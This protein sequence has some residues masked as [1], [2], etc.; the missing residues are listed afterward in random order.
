MN[1]HHDNLAPEPLSEQSAWSP[2]RE[3]YIGMLAQFSLLEHRIAHIPFPQPRYG[4]D[5]LDRVPADTELY[6]SIPNL[7]DFVSQAKTIFED[8]LKQS[9]VLQQWWS[10]GPEQDG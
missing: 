7:G 9:P 6:V 8:Q 1:S 10:Q 4:S 5:L 3:Q 2:D